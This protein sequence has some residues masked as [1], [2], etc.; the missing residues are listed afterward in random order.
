M[1]S[2]VTREQAWL[3]TGVRRSAGAC[4]GGVYGVSRAGL[5]ITRP[6][7]LSVLW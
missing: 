5:E 1:E 7:R 4:D 2:S 6:T 3:W